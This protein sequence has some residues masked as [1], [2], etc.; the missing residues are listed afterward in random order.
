MMIGYISWHKYIYIYIIYIYIYIFIFL[1]VTTLIVHLKI[2]STKQE[3]S[4]N[5]LQRCI[6]SLFLLGKNRL[7]YFLMIIVYV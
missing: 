4:V 7:Q 5:G 6:Y 3:C 1:Y 2:F